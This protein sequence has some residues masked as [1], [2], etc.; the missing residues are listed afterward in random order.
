MV[1]RFSIP[2]VLHSIH[3]R[4]SGGHLGITKTVVKHRERFYWL[5][6]KD[7]VEDGIHR[8]VTCAATKGP[9]TRL[10]GKLHKYNVGHPFERIAIDL[11]W[12]FP[13][14]RKGNR[15]ILVVADYF[16]KWCGAYPVLTI[17]ALEIAKVFVENWISHY[18]VPLELHTDQ[19]R[20]FESNLFAEMCK[21]LNINKTRTTALHQQ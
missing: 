8:C 3:D 11:T 7:D 14:S 13:M 17:D 12:P 6:Y 2:R 19:G 18:G 21:L 9:Q 4:V 5:T 20:N 16:S 1:P 10:R 15:H